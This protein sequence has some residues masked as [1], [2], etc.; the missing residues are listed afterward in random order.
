MLV[1]P[2]QRHGFGDMN[3]FFFWKMADHYTRYLMG[4]KRE[5]PVDIPEI[6]ND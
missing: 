6:H 1:L 5:R 3:E 4:D 2:G